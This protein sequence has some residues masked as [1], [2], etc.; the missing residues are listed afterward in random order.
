MHGKR[1]EKTVT[2]DNLKFAL[3]HLE[4]FTVAERIE[5]LS[6]RA[7]RA[8]VIAPA[9]QIYLAVMKWAK[10]D[11]IFVPKIGLADGLIHLQYEEYINR[12]NLNNKLLK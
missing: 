1:S 7:D 3:E 12:N 8:D 10:I 4:K 5:L 11:A 2:F 9:A 6:L